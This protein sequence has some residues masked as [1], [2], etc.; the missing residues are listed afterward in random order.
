MHAKLPRVCLPPAQTPNNQQTN[1]PYQ[2]TDTLW[3]RRRRGEEDG[4]SIVLLLTA[5]QVVLDAIGFRS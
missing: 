5:L 1:Q 3:R 2:M 4:F